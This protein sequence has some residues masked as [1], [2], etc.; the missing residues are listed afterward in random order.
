M[1]R[2]GRSDSKEIEQI[3][4]PYKSARLPCV[5]LQ[6]NWYPWRHPGRREE[7]HT[8]LSSPIAQELDATSIEEFF[9]TLLEAQA[10]AAGQA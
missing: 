10:A 2:S 8:R 9:V 5:A 7:N 3:G 1:R 6:P 4:K